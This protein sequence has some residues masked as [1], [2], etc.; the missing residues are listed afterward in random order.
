MKAVNLVP[1]ESRKGGADLRLVRGPGA[2]VVGVLAA[3]LVLVTLYV[4]ASN[5]VTSRQAQLASLRQQLSQTKALAAS[6][7]GY[8]KFAQL[9]QARV[10]TVREI[11]TSRFDW[12][13]VL[14]DLSR[15]VPANTTLSSLA[16]T[17]T[18]GASAGASS[19]SG[20]LRGALAVPAFELQGCTASQDDVARL[21]SRLRLITGVTRVTLASAVKAG[22]SAAGSAGPSTSSGSGGCK[23]NPST[24]DLVVFFQPPAGSGAGTTAGAGTPAAPTTSTS[25]TTSTTSTTTPPAGGTP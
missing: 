25:S 22:S 10:Q 9:A 20:G 24:F 14:S 13:R 21:M 18:P 8:T 17:V 5:D 23:S 12:Q 4:V 3:A 16:A 2:A 19:S 15:V 7:S 6:L 1:A 11:A